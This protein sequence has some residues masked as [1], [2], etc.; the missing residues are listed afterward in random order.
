MGLCRYA[1]P[2]TANEEAIVFSLFTESHVAH[3]V[4]YYCCPAWFNGQSQDD[5]DDFPT[6]HSKI[7]TH[8]CL[9]KWCNLSESLKTPVCVCVRVKTCCTAEYPH[10]PERQRRRLM[11]DLKLSLKPRRLNADRSKS[12]RAL[13]TVSLDIQGLNISCMF[14]MRPWFLRYKTEEK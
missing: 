12:L 14:M 5:S 7:H 4:P 2:I 13:Q 10:P 3:P 6:K 1:A 8:K 11:C 9:Y